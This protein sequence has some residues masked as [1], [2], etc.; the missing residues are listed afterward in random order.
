M[1]SPQFLSI[2]PSALY[3]HVYRVSGI[4]LLTWKCTTLCCIGELVILIFSDRGF[5]LLLVCRGSTLHISRI[6]FN[7][8][9]LIQRALLTCI[10]LLNRV[11]GL[12]LCVLFPS[13]LFLFKSLVS[14]YPQIQD[15]V[16]L[17][18]SHT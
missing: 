9:R 15:D 6:T 5:I 10:I 16:L 17:P 14:F 1:K 2:A 11:D 12:H 4:L 3:R 18:T 8:C 7:F 13:A